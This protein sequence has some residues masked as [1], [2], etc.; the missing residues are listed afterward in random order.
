MPE[1]NELDAKAV[2]AVARA[3][4]LHTPYWALLERIINLEVAAGIEPAEAEQIKEHAKGLA[5]ATA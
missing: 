1:K 4:A 2:N 3:Q 5:K